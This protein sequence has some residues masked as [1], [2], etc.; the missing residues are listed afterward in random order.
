MILG[1]Y[2]HVDIMVNNA[3]ISYRGEVIATTPEVDLRVMGVNYFGTVSLTKGIC[4]E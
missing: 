4:H 3:G 1:V 2:G